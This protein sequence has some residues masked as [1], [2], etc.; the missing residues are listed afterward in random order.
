MFLVDCC[1]LSAQETMDD[2]VELIL[3]VDN[4]LESS[5]KTKNTKKGEGFPR[6]LL[7]RERKVLM[8][9]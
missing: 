6:V 9:C 4:R 3:K 8:F 5:V 2:F 7:I 1:S